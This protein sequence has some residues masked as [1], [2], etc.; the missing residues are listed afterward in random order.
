MGHR[1]GLRKQ[2][3]ALTTHDGR[4]DESSAFAYLLDRVAAA[5]FAI[6]ARPHFAGNETSCIGAMTKTKDEIMFK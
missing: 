5:N 3:A 2:T 4:T 6:P 1:V